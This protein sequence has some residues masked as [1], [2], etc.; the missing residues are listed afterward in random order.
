[1]NG[2]LISEKVEKAISLIAQS[3]GYGKINIIIQ[4]GRPELITTVIDEKI[5]KTSLNIEVNNKKC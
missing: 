5:S 2:I 4:D 3:T 1:M